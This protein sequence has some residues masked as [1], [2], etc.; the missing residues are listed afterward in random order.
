[1]LSLQGVAE[2]GPPALYARA[3]FSISSPGSRQDY[4]RVTLAN[5]ERGLEARRF[6][7]QSSGV[8]SSVSQSNA[9]AVIPPG[10]AVVEGDMVE[11]M[12]LDLL[13]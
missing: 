10:A 12:L 2:A 5:T 6:A 9:L 11:V 8:L 13:A 7:N 1:M 3:A 4:Q